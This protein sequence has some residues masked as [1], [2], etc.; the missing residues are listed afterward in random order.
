M[1]IDAFDDTDRDYPTSTLTLGANETKHFNSNDLEMGNDDKGLA[2]G[3]GAGEG[4]WRLVLSSDLDIEVLAYIR[5]TT[6]GFLTA[7]HDI[8]P[9][10]DDRYRVPTF[11][12]G[13]N[14]DQVSRLRLVNAGDAAA[15]V[16]IRGIDDRGE[17]S[18]GTVSATV[19][20]GTSETLTAEQ[21]EAD[22]LGDGTG[23]WQLIVESDQPVIV[24]SLLS[25]PTGHLTNL[26][27][28]PAR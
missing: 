28:A 8:V 24:M 27:T 21:L 1:S 3:T 4:D 20:P 23:K 10:E 22:G 9:R 6:D 17:P 12:P 7:M 11:N 2:G 14:T 26:S 5:T 19:A 18:A 13:S 25:S 16:T 15:E